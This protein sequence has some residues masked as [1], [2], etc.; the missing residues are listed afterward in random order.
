MRLSTLVRLSLAGNRT[1][2]LRTVLTA[3]S[4]ALAALALLAAV[5]VASI[6][7][8]DWVDQP[9]G[10]RVMGPGADYS[11]ALLAEAGLRPGVVFTLAML[12]LPVLALAG[13]CIRLGAPARDR[14]LAAL[15]LGGATPGQAVLI[16]GAETAAAAALGSV[17]GLGLFFGLRELLD[18]RNGEGKLVLPVDVLPHPLLIAGALVLVPVLAGGIGV[19]L[20][21]RVVITPLGVV[22]RVREDGP[23]PWPG[24]LIGIGL[25]LSIAPKF[26]PSD[27][28]LPSWAPLAF[29][30]AGTL[31]VMAGVVLG[32]GWIS[33]TS[34]R[35]LRRYGRGAATL[36]AGGR[37]MADPWNG[38]RTLAALL[39]AVVVGAGIIGYEAMLRTEFRASEQYNAMID[40]YA[41]GEVGFGSG[42]EFYFGALR[43]IMIAVTVSIAVAAAGVLVAFVEGIVARRR[44]YAALTATGVPRRTLGNVLLWHTFV[45]LVP[46][47]LLALASG[48]ALVRMMGSEVR[49]GGEYEQCIDPNATFPTCAKETFVEPL[50]VVP[51]PIP[52]QQLVLLGAGAL[53]A[54]LLVV[55]VG[56]MVLRSSTDLEE[57]R[58]G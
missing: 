2:R 47:L 34:G 18:F 33:Y 30:G 49:H 52:L 23:G 32:T 25:P 36:L 20:M 31:C 19:L 17:L 26:L 54:M 11:N 37:L 15:R 56:V 14:R 44:A 10:V 46:A 5:T 51:I 21:R 27:T 7:G 41:T 3:G 40:P 22:R 53:V 6:Q 58:I 39:G 43:L 1:D 48:A 13:Q 57:L 12:A 9:G 55:G 28:Q 50:L 8:G 4:A 38:S 29:I 35:L 45:P 24:V 16:A 42:S